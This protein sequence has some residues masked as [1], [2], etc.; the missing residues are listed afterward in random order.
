MHKPNNTVGTYLCMLKIRDPLTDLISDPNLGTTCL[1]V[2]GI[3]LPKLCLGDTIHARVADPVHFRPD[4]DPAPDP[5]NQNFKN[6]IW[7]LLALTKNRFKQMNFFHF[8]HISSDTYLNDNYFF[9]KNGKI[10]LKMCKSSIFKIFFP[11]LYNF[12]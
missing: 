3:S 11:C 8:N 6:R 2:Y 4:P 1:L 5:G 12:T 10:Q 9:R 7:I